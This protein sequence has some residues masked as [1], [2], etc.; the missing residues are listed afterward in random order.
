MKSDN[1]NV[2]GRAKEN[3]E[4]L[5]T[6]IPLDSILTGFSNDGEALQRFYESGE[7]RISQIMERIDSL[8]VNLEKN[9][10]LDFGCGMGRLT[11]ALASRFDQSWGLDI[12]QNMIDMA[13]DTV[14]S[15]TCKFEV[16]TEPG[17]TTFDS[18]YFDFVISL[19]VIQ[20]IEPAQG[21]M[22]VDE[23]LRVL[24]PE[25]VLVLQVP[26]G[27]A[28][29]P[30]GVRL[31]IIRSLPKFI[32]RPIRSALGRPERILMHGI[33]ET[34]IQKMALKHEAIF[35]VVDRTTVNGWEN[36]MYILT[37]NSK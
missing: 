29:N 12:S 9:R 34:E 20:H 24:K 4:G 31:R 33:K 22:Y 18:K 17:L 6:D 1:K 36:R 8:G 23:L 32:S 21:P 25:G 37:R 28:W 13:N 11:S 5:A 15:S 35:L 3:W 16:L 27:P 19:L 30:L 2:F 7:K 10:A 26:H 14:G